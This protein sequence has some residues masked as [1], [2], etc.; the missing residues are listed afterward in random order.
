MQTPL[1][2]VNE[3]GPS[4]QQG[5][6][7][8]PTRK[9]QTDGGTRVENR[10]QMRSVPQNQRGSS[11]NQ[12]SGP[13]ENGGDRLSNCNENFFPEDYVVNC[14]HEGKPFPWKT[15]ICKSLLRR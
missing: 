14:V 1:V 15:Y 8:R 12:M 2:E 6:I 5:V 3:L 11:T 10:N 7:Q 9:V 13:E 4:I